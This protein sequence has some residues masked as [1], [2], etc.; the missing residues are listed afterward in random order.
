MKIFYDQGEI[1]NVFLCM[2][3]LLI[4]GDILGGRQQQ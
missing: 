3:L 2:I 1:M 4:L